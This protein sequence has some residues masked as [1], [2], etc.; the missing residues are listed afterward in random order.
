MIEVHQEED[1]QDLLDSLV[2]QD[3]QV[4]KE[5]LEGK[6]EMDFQVFLESLE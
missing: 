2:C 3:C 6:V 4:E 1:P 5:L